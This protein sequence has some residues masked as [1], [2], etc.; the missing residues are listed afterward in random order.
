MVVKCSSK[1]YASAETLLKFK[2]LPLKAFHKCVSCKRTSYRMCSP[3]EASYRSETPLEC[4]KFIPVCDDC[5]DTNEVYLCKKHYELK[6]RKNI[7]CEFTG[8][9]YSDSPVYYYH[10]FKSVRRTK[11]YKCENCSKDYFACGCHRHNSPIKYS[12]CATCL[13]DTFFCPLFVHGL[14]DHP[15]IMRVNQERSIM[16]KKQLQEKFKKMEE[17]LKLKEESINKERME[18]IEDFELDDDSSI[19]DSQAE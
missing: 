5:F 6:G 15:E 7:F 18:E 8:Q 14:Q 12:K 16:Y 10:Y 1:Y 17:D 4:N 3:C 11:Q 2:I 9:S 13:I 19:S